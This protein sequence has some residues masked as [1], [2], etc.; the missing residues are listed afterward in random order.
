VEKGKR[1][2]LR[3][4]ILAASGGVTNVAVPATAKRNDNNGFNRMYFFGL[5]KRMILLYPFYYAD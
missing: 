3:T 2:I 5:D 1:K 4:V